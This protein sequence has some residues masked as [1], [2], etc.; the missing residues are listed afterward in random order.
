MLFHLHAPAHLLQEANSEPR[1][2]FH[3]MERL[4]KAVKHA[5]ELAAF[6]D[7]LGDART[8]LETQAYH[9]WMNGTLCFELEHW[10]NALQ[11]FNRA[12]TIYKRLAEAFSEEI[13]TVYVQKV[14]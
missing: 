10:E 4:R 2:R 13:K 14:R 3:L 8:K 1:K 6:G 12:K 5:A 11:S 7:A 9:A